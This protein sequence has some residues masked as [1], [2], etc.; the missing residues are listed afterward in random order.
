MIGGINRSAAPRRSRARSAR[1]KRAGRST[2][3]GR[4]HGLE[5]D[6]VVIGAGIT[7]LT[8]AWALKQASRR[9]VV[10]EARETR[11]NESDRTTGHL[12][13]VLDTRLAGLLRRLGPEDARLMIEGQRKAIDQIESWVQSLEV[14]CGFER[15]PGYLYAASSDKVQQQ[16]LDAD[17]LAA[18]VLGYVDIRTGQIP[19]QFPV[20]GAL[21]FDEQAQ[22]RPR[23]YLAVL[24]A[25][26]GGNGSLVVRGVEVRS[27]DDDGSSRPCRV[28]TSGGD[29]FADCVIVATHVPIGGRTSIHAKLSAYRSYA[30]AAP[31]PFAL[32][33]LLWDLAE[34]YHYARTVR[35]GGAH[36]LIVGGG[37]HRVGDAVDTEAILRDLVEFTRAH[38]GTREITHRWSGQIIETPD[39]LPYVGQTS[40]GDR[41]LFATGLSG[42]GLTN[43]T[44]AGL[45][46]ADTVRGHDNKWARLL[47]PARPSSLAAVRRRVGRTL[48]AAR[49]RLTVRFKAHPGPIEALSLAPRTGAVVGLNGQTLAV[50]R[51][52]EGTLSVRSAVCPH[53]GGHVRFNRAER[54]WDCPA[55]GSRFSWSGDVL[56]GPAADGLPA[57]TL[58]EAAEVAAP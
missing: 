36:F 27:I 30:I 46:L 11:D 14:S 44:L 20:A 6:V 4:V 7:G 57:G 52:A 5:A 51:D 45:V 21:R 54:S 56:N 32:G 34:P 3:A 1:G 10:L 47:S 38:F 43:G 37:D 22:F 2:G 35:M 16:A 58:E 40:D 50:Y 29:V 49:D 18:P 23:P 41:I 53:S 48:I 8:A 13:E 9:V 12:T 28:S 24:E 33:A 17:A 55:C 15:L 31:V 19:A 26:I 25:Q 39:G 42:N